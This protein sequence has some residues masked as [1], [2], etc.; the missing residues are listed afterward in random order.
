MKIELEQETPREEVIRELLPRRMKIKKALSSVANKAM[1]KSNSI[2]SRSTLPRR[3]ADSNQRRP[4]SA[5]FDMISVCR[6]RSATEPVDHIYGLFGF[7]DGEHSSYRDLIPIDYSEAARNGYLDLFKRFAKLALQRENNLRVLVQASS[8]TR[9]P[10]LPSWCPNFMSQSATSLAIDQ[11]AAGWPSQASSLSTQSFVTDASFPNFKGRDACHVTLSTT[12]DD[13][14]IHGVAIDEVDEICISDIFDIDSSLLFVSGTDLDEQQEFAA[15]LHQWFSACLGLAESVTKEWRDKMPAE[16]WRTLVG[17]IDYRNHMSPAGE[18]MRE[19]VEYLVSWAVSCFSSDPE[20]KSL[21]VYMMADPEIRKRITNCYRH[22]LVLW[23]NRGFF[24]TKGGRTGFCSKNIR[25]GD[26]V[27]V[28]FSGSCVFL[29]RPIQ[30]TQ[31]YTLVEGGFVSKLMQGEAF[32]LLRN[33]Q[34]REQLFCLR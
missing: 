22:I 29:L 5:M 28:L 6:G 21:Y 9:L 12:C 2:A 26:V 32:E 18:E 15:K 19:D 3:M 11:Y 16:F 34:V 7:D 31:A 1:G 30:G 25:K 27:S 13:I 17:D 4:P 23:L 24:T 10:E 8:K 20:L 33:G 14:L